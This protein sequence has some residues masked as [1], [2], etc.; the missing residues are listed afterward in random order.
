LPYLLDAGANFSISSNWGMSAFEYG[1][2]M[3]FPSY[4]SPE[5]PEFKQRAKRHIEAAQILL[6]RGADP[7][8]KK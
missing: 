5:S 6:R 8:I 4:D 7:K 2:V 3:K 1:M